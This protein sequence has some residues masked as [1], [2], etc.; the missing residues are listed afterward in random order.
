MHV[1]DEL[2]QDRPV[3]GHFAAAV[4]EFEPQ[5]GLQQAQSGGARPGLR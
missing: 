5:A 3:E 1:V 2:R 4:E